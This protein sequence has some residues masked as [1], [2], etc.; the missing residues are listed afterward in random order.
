MTPARHSYQRTL[1]SSASAGSSA[2]A[3]GG[4]CSGCAAPTG[5]DA[6]LS[7]AEEAQ[8]H[9]LWRRALQLLRDTQAA[10][11]TGARG[12]AHEA[13]D[14]RMRRAAPQ[15]GAAA[16]SSA[17]ASIAQ[18]GGQGERASGVSRPLAPLRK[19]QAWEGCAVSRR[20]TA[21]GPL[22]HTSFAP[23]AV[24]ML[25]ARSVIAT[26]PVVGARRVHRASAR[27]VAL[28]CRAPRRPRTP[29]ALP[30]RGVH[31]RVPC[32]APARCYIADGCPSFSPTGP[33][34]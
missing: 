8:R 15:R 20:K 14:A 29:P 11:A 30:R 25:A 26:R 28:C 6:T 1:D 33:R 9:W 24:N 2:A 16:G 27:C 23:Q 22:L 17:G 5:P 13:D 10:A 12:A 34:L 18:D 31:L 21:G 19:M 7:A 3:T 32:A 4:G